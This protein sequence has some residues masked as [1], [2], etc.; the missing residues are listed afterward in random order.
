MKSILPCNVHNVL[1]TSTALATL[2][3]ATGTTGTGAGTH[4][5]TRSYTY[6]SILTH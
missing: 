2:T 1:L 4:D 5:L 3:L 6:N